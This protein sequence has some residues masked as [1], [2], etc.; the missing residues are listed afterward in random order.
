[1]PQVFGFPPV[2]NTGNTGLSVTTG[3]WSAS[4]VTNCNV[5]LPVFCFEN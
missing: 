4:Q 3:S 5:S 2:A 1:M